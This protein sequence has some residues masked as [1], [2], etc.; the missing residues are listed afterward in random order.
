MKWFAI[1]DTMLWLRRTSSVARARTRA[2]SSPERTGGEVVAG[3]VGVAR[4]GRAR[5]AGVAV[6]VPDDLQ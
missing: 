1:D 3:V 4:R 5:L 2:L 6:V